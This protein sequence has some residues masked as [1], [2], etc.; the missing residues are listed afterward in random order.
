MIATY[1]EQLVQAVRAGDLAAAR[2]AH[3]A[4]GALLG[5]VG[6]GAP[7]VDLAKRRGGR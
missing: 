2:L 7:V 6:P 4:L 5:D 3:G 1:A